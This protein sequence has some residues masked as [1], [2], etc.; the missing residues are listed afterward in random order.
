MYLFF[1]TGFIL[2]FENYFRRIPQYCG[3]KNPYTK[4]IRHVDFFPWN[5]HQRMSSSCNQGV[6]FAFWLL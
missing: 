3:I 2:W 6:W 1:R 4:I 5:H